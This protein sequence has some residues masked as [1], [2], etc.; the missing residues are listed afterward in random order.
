MLVTLLAKKVLLHL[1]QCIPSFQQSLI[2]SKG[3]VVIESK[4]HLLTPAA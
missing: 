4:T 1:I 3:P 2:F